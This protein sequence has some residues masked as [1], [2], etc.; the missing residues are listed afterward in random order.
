MTDKHGGTRTLSLTPTA[1]WRKER[2]RRY[3]LFPAEEWRVVRVE[4]MGA[5]AE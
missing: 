4:G 1:D 3:L 5:L 2:T